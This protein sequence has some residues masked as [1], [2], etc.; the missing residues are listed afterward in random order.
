MSL[1]IIAIRTLISILLSIMALYFEKASGMRSIY[2]MLLLMGFITLPVLRIWVKKNG[3]YFLECGIVFGLNYMTRFSLNMV[4]IAFYVMILLESFFT[5]DRDEVLEVG[6]LSAV[7][8]G[9]NFYVLLPYGVNYRLI[10]EMV[11][12]ELM[13]MLVVAMLYFLKSY[14]LEK[15]KVAS[16]L[17]ENEQKREALEKALY[18]VSEQNESY[19]HAQDEVVRLTRVAERAELAGALHDTIGHEITGLIMQIEMLNMQYKVPLAKE[20]ADHAREILRGMR[21]VVETLQMHSVSESTTIKLKQKITAFSEQTG[22]QVHLN[23]EINMEIFEDEYKQMI[24]RTV[25]EALTNTAKHSNATEI[26]LIFN[27]LTTGTYFLKLMD[28]GKNEKWNEV[29]SGEHAELYSE[30]NG[31]RF[32]RKRVQ[33]LGGIVEYKCERDG[34]FQIMIQ[35]EGG[36]RD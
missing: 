1:K 14:R 31:L 36:L 21:Q 26:W 33:K 13:L 3:L 29:I 17:E 5:S 2:L 8:M 20:A 6:F 15:K 24:Y 4:F 19:E 7:L 11:F 18:T 27:T 10:T 25:L 35:F 16:L 30:G 9:I 34:G 28:N 22:I 23:F 12:L 32:I